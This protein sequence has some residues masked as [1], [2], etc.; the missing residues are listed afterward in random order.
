MT[1]KLVSLLLAVMLAAGL[2]CFPAAAA[3]YEPDFEVTSKAVYLENIDTGTVVYEKA[4]GE[5]M[6]PA[7]LT[8]IMT[9]IL[10]LEHVKDLDGETAEYPMYIQD[11]LYGTNA[12]LGGLRVGEKLS[13]R[14]LLYSALV[15]SANES[16]MILAD[17]VGAGSIAKFV[18]M[19]NQKAAEL[20]CTGT[21]FTNPTGLHN[22]NHYSTARDL[23][24]MAKYA[25]ENDIFA[26]IVSTYAVNIGPTNKRQELWQY[27]TNRMLIPSSVYY[28]SPLI[29]IKT[30]TTDEG[31]KCL[32]S[33]TDADGYRYLCILLGAPTNTAESYVNF[34]ETRQIYRWVYNNFSLQTLLEGGELMAEVPVKYSGDGKIARLATKADV[35][36]LINDD[37]SLDSIRYYAELPEYVEAP[38]AAG[39]EIGT[40]HIHLMDEEIAT[41]ALVATEEFTLS[42]FLKI[43]GLIG[44]ALRSPVVIVIVVLVVLAI[45]GY[46]VLMIRHNKKKRRRRYSNRRY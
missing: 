36:E 34:V 27:T 8:K 29:G 30:G 10:V 7:S 39:D 28:Y 43:L 42:W 4:A 45:A 13:I 20:G 9:A 12:S 41:V 22:D 23:A 19:M 31:G 33:M 26:E 16:A 18:E 11:L 1:R 32:A 40:L 3:T 21:H 17:Y 6:Y 35:I 24:I 37:I 46:V 5:R 14:M 2:L 15:Q 44:N 38:I 25:M